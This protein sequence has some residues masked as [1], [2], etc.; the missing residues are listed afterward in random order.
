[1]TINNLQNLN[2]SHVTAQPVTNAVDVGRFDGFAVKSARSFNRLPGGRLRQERPCR[3]S[4]AAR[5]SSPAKAGAM[6]DAEA[7][8]ISLPNRSR[9]SLW[10]KINSHDLP[11]GFVRAMAD[12]ITHGGYIGQV[13]MNLV[14]NARDAMPNGGKISIATNNVVL[15]EDYVLTHPGVMAWWTGPPSRLRRN[16]DPAHL[17]RG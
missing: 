12:Q 5:T 3:R 16:T 1:L 8:M 2:P 9:R 14:V 4:L 15:G 10:V 13:L 17:R 11:D 7:V 6:L